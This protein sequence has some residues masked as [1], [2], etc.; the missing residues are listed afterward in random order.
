[1]AAG[2]G[3]GIKVGGVGDMSEASDLWGSGVAEAA[4]ELLR[5]WGGMMTEY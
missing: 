5:V 4:R 1:M 2:V 3:D